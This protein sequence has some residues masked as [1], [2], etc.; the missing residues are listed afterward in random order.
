MAGIGARDDF[1]VALIF[2]HLPVYLFPSEQ[3]DNRHSSSWAES[4]T[5]VVR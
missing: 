1:A 3:Q 2:R 5:E 4:K